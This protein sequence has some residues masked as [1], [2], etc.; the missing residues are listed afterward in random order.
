M[1]AFAKNILSVIHQIKGGG[2]Y[3]TSGA[4]T[5]IIPGLMV[6]NALEISFPIRVEQ[7]KDLVKMAHKAPFGKGSKTIIDANVRSV[8][9]IDA[10]KISFLNPG[11]QLLIATLIKKVK[12]GLGIEKTEVTASLYKLLIYEN[13]DFFVAHK[14]S[15]KEKGMFGTLIIG[16]P[17]K[18]TGGALCVRFGSKEETIGFEE[19]VN[20]YQIPFAAFYADC[21]HEIEKITSGYRICLAYNLIQKEGTDNLQLKQSKTYV[22]QIADLLKRHVQEKRIVI[23]LNHQYTP[24]NFSLSSL[25]HNDRHKTD[26]IMKAA[27]A[28][29]YYVKLGLFTCYKM[30]DMEGDFYNDWDGLKGGDGAMGEVHEEYTHIENWANDG[31]PGLGYFIIDEAEV[32]RDF[33]ISKG[34]PIA[35]EEEGYMGNYGMT[36]EYWYHYGAIVLWRKDQHLEIVSKLGIAEK[37]NWLTYYAGKN[38]NTE[39]M[40]FI[41]STFAEMASTSP[42]S[43]RHEKL[44]FNIVA[45]LLV[46]L[47]A[48]KYLQSSQGVELLTIL[49]DKIS[50]Y[51]WEKLIEHFGLPVFKNVFL[52][53]FNEV[54]QSKHLLELLLH[55]S[56][57]ANTAYD[58][59]ITGLLQYLPV[60][61]TKLNLP[62]KAN[63]IASLSV[64]DNLIKLSKYKNT[65]ADWVIQITKNLTATLTRSFVNKVLADAL[66]QNSVNRKLILYTAILK[67]CKHYLKVSIANKPLPPATFTRHIP[68]SF[69]NKKMLSVISSFIL[70]PT[71]DLFDYRVNQQLRDEMANAV[72]NSKIDLRTETIKKGSPHTLR[73]TK[74]RA[75][76]LRLFKKWEEDVEY[77]ERLERIYNE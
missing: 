26:V 1:E 24:E 7:I 77:L 58:S 31:L 2:D 12:A 68:E 34:D 71:E 15:E 9:E 37:L 64:V 66:M 3:V 67:V 60:S 16:L 35:K 20:Q 8:W 55:L 69:T 76:Y 72:S 23:L 56:G 48:T 17:S 27:E 5:M 32:I 62:E 38:C 53:S 6:D 36:I 14:D 21:E 28:A 59:F 50:F 33:D 19:A 39:E 11:W 45:V 65:D 46:Q 22:Q 52:N 51:Q 44:D 63:T 61:I 40:A 49:F 29:G 43:F 75:S 25:K 54:K 30:G 41:R 73:L 70:S 57:K 4:I 18:H 10:D 13:G 47:N 42:S 74:T